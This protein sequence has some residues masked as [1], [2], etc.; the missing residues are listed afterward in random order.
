LDT[1]ALLVYVLGQTVVPDAA[2][3]TFGLLG[4][5]VAEAAAMAAVFLLWRLVDRRSLLSFGLNPHAAIPRCFRGA[6]IAAL[7][8]GFVVLVGYTLIDGAT[9]DV[10]PDPVHAIVVLIGGLI[11]YLIQ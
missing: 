6:V 1:A 4:L 9:W 8:M 2:R 7:M 11:G 3:G 5:G 10:N